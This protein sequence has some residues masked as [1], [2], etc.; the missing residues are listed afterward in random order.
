MKWTLNPNTHPSMQKPKPGSRTSPRIQKWV[1]ADGRPREM[2]YIQTSDEN[3]TPKPLNNEDIKHNLDMPLNAPA[4][5]QDDL[6]Y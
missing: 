6:P 2:F 1:P 3:G 4:G 5:I